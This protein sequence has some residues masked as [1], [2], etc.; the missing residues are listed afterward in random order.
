MSL[1]QRTKLSKSAWVLIGLMIVAV[2]AFPILHITG[3]IDLSFIGETFMGFMEWAAADAMNGV[4]VIGGSVVG[5]MLIM[6]TLQ[7]YIIGTKIGTPYQQT[8]YG[9]GYNPPPTQPSSGSG[10][11]DETVI[12]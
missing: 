12:S 8:Q 11:Q 3:V 4:L 5:G 2:I 9:G 7:K 10:Q 1:T 6:Y